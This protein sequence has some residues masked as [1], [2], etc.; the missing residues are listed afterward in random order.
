MTTYTTVSELVEAHVA[1][2]RRHDAEAAASFYADDA[3]YELVAVG[4]RYEGRQAV[5]DQY[6][7][8]YD[9]IEGL[10]FVIDGSVEDA[11]TLVHWGR[12]TGTVGG[13]PIDVPFSARFETTNGGQEIQGESVLYDLLTLAEQAGVDPSALRPATRA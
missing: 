5:R 13:R 6:A 11:E 4:V 10:D 7:R 12:F 9:L 8:S 1:A 2:E 3:F